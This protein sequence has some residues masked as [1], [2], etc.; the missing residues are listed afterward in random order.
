MVSSSDYIA[1]APDSENDT[2]LL[3]SNI[4]KRFG[5]VVALDNVNLALRRGEV[6]GLVGD[7]GA[8]KSTLMKIIAGVL[9][10]DSG[11]LLLDGKPLAISTPSDAVHAGIQTVFQDLALCEN[12]N[13]SANLF[14]GYEQTKNWLGFLPHLLRPLAILEMEEQSRQALDKLDIRTLRSGA[15]QNR[16]A[17]GWTAASCGHRAGS[18]GGV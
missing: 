2:H 11:E 18:A 9:A 16:L 17:I 12:L 7:N 14:L 5:A 13:V 6:A 3:V 1:N 4:S 15:N 10:P 8:D